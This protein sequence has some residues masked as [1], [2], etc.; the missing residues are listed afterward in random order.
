MFS[1][2]RV[3]WQ[4]TRMVTSNQV[5]KAKAR[6]LNRTAKARQGLSE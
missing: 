6:Q 1:E 2:P 3:S 4:E 5:N